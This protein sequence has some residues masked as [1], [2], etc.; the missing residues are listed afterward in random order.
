VAAAIYEV[1]AV[2]HLGPAV[3]DHVA[4]AAK[5][6]I[7]PPALDAILSV[8]EHPGAGFGADPD[9]ARDAVL[10]ASLKSALGELSSR[11]G[12]DMNAWSWGRLHHATW[13]PAI[14][15]IADADTAA[16]MTL[17][18]LPIPGGAS[19]PKAAAYTPADFDVSHGA[20]VRMVLDVGAWDNSMI[21]NTPGESG[22]PGSAH[23]GDLFPLWAAGA[24]VP[25]FFSRAAVEAQA[26]R[27]IDLTPG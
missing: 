20:S 24:Y 4:P 12:P 16:R 6:A 18:P 22:D 27:V 8:L 23:Y 19:T 2:K 10:L 14:A 1:W 3:I 21:I 11:L 5:P 26:E 9:R 25:L 15:A 7:G 13:T 17:G